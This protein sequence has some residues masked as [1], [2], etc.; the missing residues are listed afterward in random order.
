MN[1]GPFADKKIDAPNTPRATA[2]ISH[3]VD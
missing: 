3:T 1:G 2:E